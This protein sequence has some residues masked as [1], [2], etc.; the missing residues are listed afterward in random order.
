ME[1]PL[2]ELKP[3]S[4]FEV[5]SKQKYSTGTTVENLAR[6]LTK[7]QKKSLEIANLLKSFGSNLY[8]K[9]EMNEE[10][11]N[12]I[13]LQRLKQIDPNMNFDAIGGDSFES[14]FQDFLQNQ[15]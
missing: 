7:D 13:A 6:K 11:I 8:I 3:L 15:N 2:G 1:S 14:G 4:P 12:P 10:R 9:D 5:K